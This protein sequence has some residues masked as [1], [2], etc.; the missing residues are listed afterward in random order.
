MVDYESNVLL[1]Q[2][3]L[4][5]YGTEN[6]ILPYDFGPKD[7]LHF[8]QRCVSWSEKFV[9]G[10]TR[11]LDLGCAVGGATFAL[12]KTFKEAVGID[13]SKCFIDTAIELQQ[14]GKFA[15]EFTIE[16]DIKQAAIAK[17]DSEIDRK[18][19]CF[20]QG[21]AEQLDK[22]LG[23][24]DLVLM[25]NLI[26]RLPQP[27]NCLNQIVDFISPAGLLMIASPYTWLETI[28]Q[29]TNWL[30]GYCGRENPVFT[31]EILAE[32]LRNSFDLLHRDNLPFLIR[33]HA[34]KFQ[35]GVSEA[36]L[37]QKK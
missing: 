5:H 4:F 13:Y 20:K 15:Y 37:W 1:E 36:T 25:L 22:S 21:D 24:F 31:F 30:G 3:L 14:S 11:A 28:T 19:V 2:Y 27:K 23:Q 35:W 26:D 8:P 33:E 7:S 16:G 32:L 18:R 12:A 29:K 17:V 34:R 9:K 10:K 6:E